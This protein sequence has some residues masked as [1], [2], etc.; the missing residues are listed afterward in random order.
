[1]QL[2]VPNPVDQVALIVSQTIQS[3]LN[4]SDFKRTMM[5]GLLQLYIRELS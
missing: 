3:R 4:T 1:M 2:H 5:C